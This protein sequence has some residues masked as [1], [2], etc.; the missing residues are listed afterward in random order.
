[1]AARWANWSDF[2]LQNE[3]TAILLDTENAKGIRGFLIPNHDLSVAWIFR[4]RWSLRVREF[5][6]YRLNPDRCENVK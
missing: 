4:T 3:V 5:E 6:S 1:M 2:V